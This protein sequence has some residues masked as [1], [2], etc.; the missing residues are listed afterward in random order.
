LASYKSNTAEQQ[1]QFEPNRRSKEKRK[2]KG[3]TSKHT[4]TRRLTQA[5]LR[6]RSEGETSSQ[7]PLSV[8]AASS[9]IPPSNDSL[10]ECVCECACKY[11]KTDAIV[12][13]GKNC[14]VLD[15]SHQ[16]IPRSRARLC[17]L[18]DL[19]FGTRRQGRSVQFLDY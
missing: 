14:G 17:V 18:R 8:L 5:K 15:S 13:K 11:F 4:Y 12:N 6:S 1:Q 2:K 16:L 7:D 9:P 19:G 3:E 10:C